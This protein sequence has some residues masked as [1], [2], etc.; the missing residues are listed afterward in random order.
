MGD[1]FCFK[2]VPRWIWAVGILGFLSTT[3]FAAWRFRPP[4][5]VVPVGNKQMEIVF[6]A[7]D[8]QGKQLKDAILAG[9]S[10]IPRQPV[11]PGNNTS[12]KL[13]KDFNTD[14]K[15]EFENDGAHLTEDV[16]WRTRAEYKE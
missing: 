16:V 12:C 7:Y 9:P 10:P 6:Y 15:L 4:P 3:V 5:K 14:I 8:T 1:L 13:T 11:I 2:C